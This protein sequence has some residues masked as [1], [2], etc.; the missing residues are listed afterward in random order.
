MKAF[1][2]R[3][4]QVMLQLSAGKDSLACLKLLEAEGAMDKVLVVWMN[5]GH[6]HPETIA[7]MEKIKARVPHFVELRGNID[8]WVAMH[9]LPK[10]NPAVNEPHTFT[11]CAAN[12]WQPMANFLRWTNITGVIRGQK[13]VD[14]LRAPISS[15]YIE[16]GVEYWFPLEAWSD[17]D[18]FTYCGEELPESYKREPKS[19]DCAICTGYTWRLSNGL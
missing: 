15:G 12:M 4:P 8:N 18:V 9:G 14:V 2:A 19:V 3:H 16:D 13:K 10:D 6:P 7:Y 5:P 1:L 11:C 17:D